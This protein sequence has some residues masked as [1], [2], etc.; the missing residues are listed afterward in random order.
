MSGKRNPVLEQWPAN[1]HERTVGR[2]SGLLDRIGVRALPARC[3][4]GSNL[5]R[6]ADAQ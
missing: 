1:L 6:V 4:L 2:G 5:G 3:V